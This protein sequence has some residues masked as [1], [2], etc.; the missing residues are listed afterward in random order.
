MLFMIFNATVIFEIGFVRWFG[1]AGCV[2]VMA[3]AAKN[4]TRK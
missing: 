4:V 2:A 1:L 3:L